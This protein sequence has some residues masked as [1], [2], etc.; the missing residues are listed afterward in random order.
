MYKL[1][2]VEDDVFYRY[3]IRNFLEWEKLGFTIMA[4]AMNGKCALEILKTEIPD[5]VLTDISMPEMNGIELLKQIRKLYPQVKCIVLSS[6][7]DFN[8]VK[9]A[10]KLGAADYIL[11]YDLKEPD[12]EAMLEKIKNE[13]E[14]ERKARKKSQFVA[15]NISIISNDFLRNLLLNKANSRENIQKLWEYAGGMDKPV[16]ITVVVLKFI[17]TREKSY[18]LSR[19]ILEANISK[20]EFVASV[21]SDTLAV[22]LSLEQ[23]R[24][25]IRIF[26]YV[27]RKVTQIYQKLKEQKITGFSLGVSDQLQHIGDIARIFQQAVKA[28][29]QSLYEGYDKVFFYSN[30]NRKKETM[31]LEASIEKLAE[32]I[33]EGQ[34]DRVRQELRLIVENMYQTRPEKKKLQRTFYLLFHVL[35]RVSIEE[36]IPSESVLGV[37]VI[38]EEW[39][40]RFH[41]IQELEKNLM[42]S[43]EKL[44]R[45]IDQ[46][47]H[48]GPNPN[49]RQAAM[50]MNYIEKNYMKEVSLEILS[51]ELG[52]TPNYLCKIF[53]NSTGMKLTQYINQVRI[54]G[55]K[56]LLR[57]TNMKAHEVAETV[58]FASASYFST[59]FK[60]VTGKTVSEYKDS[61]F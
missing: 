53:K 30:L 50:I 19:K 55:A 35:Y 37:K 26:E 12:I 42:E 17:E 54:E 25:A 36:N 28:Q 58:G 8:F 14:S 10:M 3:E 47:D 56:K 38:S 60:Q 20:L 11:K 27:T 24:S 49:N 21:D 1:M 32:E 59:I 4:E 43:Y 48:V 15:E 45:K 51:E 40:G 16:N 22:L 46:R 6:Y 31:N 33:H 41:S 61:I 5:L 9:D 44:I 18:E 23:E 52:L 13:I 29:E 2:I 39:Y 57:N 7:D 34:T